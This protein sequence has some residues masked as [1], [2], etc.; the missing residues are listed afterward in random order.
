[1]A[2]E[3]KIIDADAPKKTCCSTKSNSALN[4]V[5]VLL[6]FGVVATILYLMMS[7]GGSNDDPKPASGQPV[8][9]GNHLAKQVW[10]MK[11]GDKGWVHENSLSRDREGH[12]FLF[13]DARVVP[14]EPKDGHDFCQVELTNNGFKATLRCGQVW[15]EGFFS[16]RFIHYTPVMQIEDHH[17]CTPD[18]KGSP[19][20]AGP[21]VPDGK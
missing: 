12:L 7:I 19:P 6:V 2:E 18:M 16:S 3:I 21:F 1:M 4:L 10:Q 14:A 13:N 15:K 20:P 9:T 11:V 17:C 5:G 8:L